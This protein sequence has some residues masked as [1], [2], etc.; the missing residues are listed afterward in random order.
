MRKQHNKIES[1]IKLRGDKKSTVLI[2]LNSAEN[3][4]TK[5][6]KEKNISFLILKLFN[7]IAVYLARN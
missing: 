6:K 1:S 4:S 2:F 5:H 7:T 3:L